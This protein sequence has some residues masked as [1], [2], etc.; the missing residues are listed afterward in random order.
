VNNLSGKVPEPIGGLD[1]E[2]SPPHRRRQRDNVVLLGWTA[3]FSGMSQEMVYPLLPTFV[4]VALGS[5]KTTLGAVEGALAV[6][7]TVARLG[8]ARL[9]DRGASP[10][11]LTQWSYLL[12]LVAR[13]L[14]A[15]APTVGVIGALRIVDGLGKG[16]KDAPRDTLVASDARTGREGRSFG[17]QRALDTFGSVI[18]PLAAGGLL[19]VLGHGPTG[20]RWT[21]ALAAVPALGAAW[22]LRR[23][24]DVPPPPHQRAGREPLGRP[25]GWLLVAVM[26]FGFAN[27]SDTL[28][29][30]R[31]SSVG[32]SAADLAFV[33]AAFNLAYALMAMPAGVVSDRFG[34]RPLLLIGWGIYAA[35]YA[36][37]AFAT[38]T[39]QVLGLFVLYGVY[40]ASAEG[41]LKAWVTTLVPAQRRGAAYGLLAA[42]SGLLLLPASV[43][44]GWLWDHAGPRPAF[45]LGTVFS[46]AALAVVA[47]APG[48]RSA[49][50]TS[51]KGDDR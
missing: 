38:S 10:K 42:A 17:L 18:G 43:V 4:V 12:S 51:T 2:A 23:V 5:S 40:F 33:Y 15:L 28:L 19:L 26:L 35:V 3:L 20:L 50:A 41:T 16:G 36:G 29:L 24:H 13:P 25:F 34:R 1:V 22:T 6:G 9:V 47:V 46:T 49:A 8:S 27:S 7:V 48:L 44:A 14:L 30:L 37:F 31:A 32:F 39:W 21:F 11:R 45:L